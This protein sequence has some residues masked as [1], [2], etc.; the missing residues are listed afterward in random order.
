[1][2]HLLELYRRPYDPKEPVV[3]FDESSVQL[4]G[5]VRDGLPAKPGRAA[6]HD[7]EYVRGGTANLLMIGE[8]LA[9][10]LSWSPNLE[11]NSTSPGG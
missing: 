7:F 3:G 1:M 11:P 5:K 4:L 2:E 6:R 10:A 9:G 8:T